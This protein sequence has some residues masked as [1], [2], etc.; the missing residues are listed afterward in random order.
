MLLNGILCLWNPVHREKGKTE[1]SGMFL[2]RQPL[3]YYMELEN[4]VGSV[5][6]ECNKICLDDDE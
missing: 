3:Q 2:I 5:Q 6:W 4:R 1:C